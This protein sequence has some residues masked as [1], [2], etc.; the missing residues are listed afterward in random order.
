MSDNNDVESRNSTLSNSELIKMQRDMRKRKKRKIVIIVL[1]CVAAAFALI[2]VLIGMAINAINDMINKTYLNVEQATATRTS[3]SQYVE[4]GGGIG[5][6]FRCDL[7][8]QRK[9]RFGRRAAAKRV[10]PG[11]ERFF[12]EERELFG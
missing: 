12:H 7:R 8:H 9:D 5:P 3:L 10:I 11:V 2:A 6:D 1:I 4:S